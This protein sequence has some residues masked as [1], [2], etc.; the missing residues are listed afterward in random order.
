VGI[1][2][3]LKDQSKCKVGGLCVVM[4][5]KWNRE[6][7]IGANGKLNYATKVVGLLMSF[8]KSRQ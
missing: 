7:V 3:T 4:Q 5:V 8:A 2:I 6:I 1:L